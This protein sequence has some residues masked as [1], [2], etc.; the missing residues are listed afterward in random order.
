MRRWAA[1]VVLEAACALAHAAPLVPASDAE[2]LEVLPTPSGERAEDRRLRA[3][4]AA[5][6]D[7]AATAVRL[8]A[9]LLARARERGDPR[10][11]GAALAVLARWP[12]PRRAPDDVL[13][14][15]ATLQQ[16]LHAFDGAIER[17]RILVARSSAARNAQAWLTLATV[18]RVRGRLTDAEAACRRV[19]LAG[20]PLYGEACGADL[21]ALRGDVAPARRTLQSLL[22]NRAHADDERV[23]L[24]TSLAE[25]EE[26][27]G[28]PDA[29]R[30]AYEQIARLGGDSYAAIAQ[31]DF[32]LAQGEPARALAALRGQVRS[33]PVLLRLA[34]AG[35]RAKARNAAAD[36]AELRE[37]IRLANE[38][39]EAR[40]AH[41]RE[42]A[43]FA[44]WVEDRPDEAVPLARANL[45]IQ[46][47]PLDFLIA[48]E[49]ARVAHDAAARDEVR[50]I[51]TELPLHDRRLDAA[52]GP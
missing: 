48:A 19:S 47:E 28:R 39:P 2:V 9:R 25:L 17:L 11:A 38:R 34:I 21:A 40:V 52:L 42:H 23:F 37:R 10:E 30:A 33:D 29:A 22:Q 18:L 3:A 50:R 13:L 45:A 7:D 15:Q 14:L 27:D 20:A 16:H 43:M 8:A 12:D 49:A 5:N 46:R 51:R 32:L 44:L 4:L 41:G 35:R 1:W 26:R 24:L 6:P 36:A 31:A